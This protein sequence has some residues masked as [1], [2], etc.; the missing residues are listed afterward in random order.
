MDYKKFEENIY[1][2]AVEY[3]R[4]RAKAMKRVEK[5]QTKLNF[6]NEE[7]SDII[8]S[9][10]NLLSKI[11]HKYYYNKIV[12]TGK[13]IYTKQDGDMP[14]DN[15]NT[16]ISK[17]YKINPLENMKS[18][19]NNT[20]ATKIK[21]KNKI[22]N[23]ANYQ[24]YSIEENY[25]NLMKRQFIYKEL[26]KLDL[27]PKINDIIMCNKKCDNSKTRIVK[28][29]D[30][31][32]YIIIYDNPADYK[33]LNAEN[34]KNLSSEDKKKLFN[35]LE[36]FAQKILDNKIVSYVEFV[37]EYYEGGS[38]WLFFDNNLKIVMMMT[39]NYSMHQFSD[40]EKATMNK[41]TFYKKLTK[42]LFNNAE[43]IVGLYIKK[44]IIL[45]LL[46]EKQLIL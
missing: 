7:L 46:Q 45:R 4:G 6:T 43:R 14:E 31:G 16:C 21:G 20:F 24:D 1:K 26:A 3:N 44:Y 29:A 37:G 30:S 39:D 13:S 10:D 8:T 23:F 19:S 34:I 41:K 15:V 42:K 2:Y 9:F 25:K 11:V 5:V 32:Y 40:K 12:S 38:K 27:I 22:I 28:T 33:K 18:L 36:I 17:M 35:N